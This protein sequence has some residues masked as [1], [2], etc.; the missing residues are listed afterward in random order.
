[1]SFW[2]LLLGKPITNGDRF[3][4]LHNGDWTFLPMLDAIAKAKAKA[5][6]KQSKA[7][8]SK[9]KQSITFET[10]I[11]WS[12]EIGQA[13]SKAPAERARSGVK[14]HVPID[15]VGSAKIDEAF[16][17]EIKAPGVEIRKFHKRDWYAITK[18]IIKP[19]ACY[20]LRTGVPDSQAAW[21]LPP[22]G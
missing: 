11:Y 7:K 5:K 3:E 13:F 22:N 21:K 18:S 10:Y 19:I 4:A 17:N 16:L 9:A 20:W 1:M 8:Q 2:G 6:A 15:W 14:V 12:G